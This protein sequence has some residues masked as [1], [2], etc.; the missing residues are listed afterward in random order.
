MDCH[1]N[2]DAAGG[3]CKADGA[4]YQS[5]RVNAGSL[6]HIRG[7]NST[8]LN[9]FLCICIGSIITTHEAQEEYLIRMTL[10]SSFCNLALLQ[11]NTQRLVGKYM[12]ACI[13]SSFNLPAMLRRSGNNGNSVN[14]SLFQH[15]TEIGVNISN[16]QFRLCVFQ[17]SRHDG[18]CSSQLCVRDFECNIVRVYLAQTAQACNTNFDGLHRQFLL[19]IVVSLDSV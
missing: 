2:E 13:Q 18:A 3:S 8:F 11:V 5:F 9:L 7:T 1:V 4:F 6:Y 12:L 19:K 14:V 10:Y 17:F 16:A 15:F